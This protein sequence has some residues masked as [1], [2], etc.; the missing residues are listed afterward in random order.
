MLLGEFRHAL[1][2]KGRIILPARWREELG[3]NVVVTLGLD[4]CLYLMAAPAFAEL[5]QRFDGLALESPQ[6]R[7]YMRVFFSQASEQA[8]D[9]Q[10]RVMIPPN[11]RAVASL[12]RDVVL[13][14]ASKRAE[15]WDRS[16]YEAYQQDAQA[17][18]EDIATSLQL[19]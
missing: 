10:G 9:G 17:Q 1:D 19:N 16:R 11:L 15:I 14:G 3:L 13:A 18:Y 2:P 12:D 6:A 7:K 5:A 4:Q 8:V